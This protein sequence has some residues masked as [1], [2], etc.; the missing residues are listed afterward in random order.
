M[1]GHMPPGVLLSY[2]SKESSQ[3]FVSIFISRKVLPRQLASTSNDYEKKLEFLRS[4]RDKLTRAVEINPKATTPEGLLAVLEA[5]A[6][7]SCTAQR[8]RAVWS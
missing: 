4:A 3:F 6:H 5:R 8:T 2:R 7:P 1:I